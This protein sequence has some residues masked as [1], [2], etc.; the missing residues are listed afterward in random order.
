[1][2]RSKVPPLV[3]LPVSQLRFTELPNEALPAWG[4]VDTAEQS[5]WCLSSY[6]VIKN[7]R[8]VNTAIGP[9][10]TLQTFVPHGHSPKK[11]KESKTTQALHML[12]SIGTLP[13]GSGT[14]NYTNY[15][16]MLHAVDLNGPNAYARLQELGEWLRL[17][18]V[19]LWRLYDSAIRR[20][21]TSA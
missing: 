20:L 6:D 11:Q 4:G 14:M 9:R 1:M 21:A 5:I 8:I 10:P 18:H 15:A 7:R 16:D 3:L 13:S 19:S 17:Q 12:A 2:S